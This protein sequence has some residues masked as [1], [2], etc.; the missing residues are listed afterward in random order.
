MK[1]VTNTTEEAKNSPIVGL[2]NAMNIEAQ[3]QA[4]QRQ[5]VNSCQL[6]S[7]WNHKNWATLK[8]QYTKMGI[9]VIETSK[10][11]DTLF[12]DVELPNGWKKKGTDHSM[13]N[14]LLDDKG[15]VRASIFYK[16]AF[17]DRDAHINFDRRF[18]FTVVKWLQQEEKGHYEKRMVKV[19]NPDYVK[20]QEERQFF[21][22]KRE[23]Y[24]EIEYRGGIVRRYPS[25]QQYITKEQD[26]WVPKF[27]DNYHEYRNTPHYLEITDGKEVIFSTKDKPKFFKRK[28]T[29]DTHEEWWNGYERVTEEL[30]EQAIDYLDKNFPGWNDIN[31][32]WD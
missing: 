16:A 32:Y 11:D 12:M 23:Y 3:E 20:Q 26:E 22:D 1:R 7:K 9:K 10:G 28:Y 24:Q 30:R 15:R 21:G 17:Y 27:K 4:G 13:W 31:A 14:E 8:E 29:E 5:L 2:V 25:A 19:L 18:N 6:P